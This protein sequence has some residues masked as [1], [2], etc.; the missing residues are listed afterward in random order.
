MCHSFVQNE[1]CSSLL[2]D[3]KLVAKTQTLLS[4]SSNLTKN[5]GT[6]IGFFHKIRETLMRKIL[7]KKFNQIL[8]ERLQNLIKLKIIIGKI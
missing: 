1:R 8:P 7:F 2:F 3:V 4:E 6:V 5:K